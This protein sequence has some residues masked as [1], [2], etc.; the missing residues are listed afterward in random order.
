MIDMGWSLL[1]LLIVVVQIAVLVYV[2]SLLRRTAEGVEHVGAVL[3]RGLA[4]AFPFDGFEP[5]TEVEWDGRP[6]EVEG[7]TITPGARGRV[8]DHGEELVVTFSGVTFPCAEDDVRV[9]R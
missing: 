5:E 3:E 9:P 4:R 1:G 2:L 7:V 6:V 8:V